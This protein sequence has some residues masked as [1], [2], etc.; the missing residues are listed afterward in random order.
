MAHFASSRSGSDLRHLNCCRLYLQVTTLT[1]ICTGDGKQISSS[2]WEGNPPP[3]SQ[4]HWPRQPRPPNWYWD[5]W[6]TALATLLETRLRLR[7]PLGDWLPNHGP[8]WYYSPMDDRLYYRTGNTWSSFPHLPL[9]S[10]TRLAQTRF[11]TQPQQGE[12]LPPDLRVA[13]II[14]HPSSNELTGFGQIAPDE[15]H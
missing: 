15:L 6:R 12:S 10:R 2:A 7:H 3:S 14:P 8:N 1:D 11:S 5:E 4:P 9:R 13:T